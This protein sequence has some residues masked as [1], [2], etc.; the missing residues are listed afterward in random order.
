MISD[1][2]NYAEI[3]K[4]R[5]EKLIKETKQFKRWGVYLA[6]IVTIDVILRT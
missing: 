4:H 6:L 5:H 3:A 2:K 1:Y